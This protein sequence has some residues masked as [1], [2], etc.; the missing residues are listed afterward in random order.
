[1]PSYGILCHVTLERLDVSD[2]SVA[3]IIKVTVSA[4]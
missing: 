4:S 1:M 2:E 3:S